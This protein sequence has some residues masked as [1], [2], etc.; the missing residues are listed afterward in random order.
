M[1]DLSKPEAGRS[2]AV[3]TT[4]KA[5][6][7]V[8]PIFGGPAVELFSAVVKPPIEKRR[9]KWIESIA[10]RLIE[11][12]NKIES[13]SIQEL[14][15]NELFISVLIEALKVVISTHQEEKINSLNNAVLNAAHQSNIN[16]DKQLIFI[17]FIDNLTELHIRTLKLLNNPVAWFEQNSILK[18]ITDMGKVKQL[19]FDRNGGVIYY[20]GNPEHRD[21]YFKDYR[22]INANEYQKEFESIFPEIKNNK[23]LYNQILRELNNKDLI[24]PQSINAININLDNSSGTTNL[25]KEFIDF[26]TCPTIFGNIL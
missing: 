15:Q 23:L 8:Y 24:I 1:D 2:D 14:S 22:V 3:H 17:K 16:D 19:T 12:E 18:K 21:S 10:N 4:L 9:D 26:I 20:E 7:S 13:F 11:L 6:L 5:V 25:G